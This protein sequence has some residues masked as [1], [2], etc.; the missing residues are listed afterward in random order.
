M[1]FKHHADHRHKLPKQKYRVTHWAEYEAGLR[2]RG[3]IPFWIS[4]EAI[5]GWLAPPRKTPGGQPR[6]SALA[7]SRAAR[8]NKVRADR[9]PIPVLIDST[10]LKIDGAGQWLEDKQGCKSPRQW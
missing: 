7:V 3:S 10:G 9:E 4:K 1:P 2:E 6:Y 5:S 8:Q